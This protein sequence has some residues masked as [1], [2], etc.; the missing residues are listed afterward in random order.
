MLRE[1]FLWNQPQK[2]PDFVPIDPWNNVL[3]SDAWAAHRAGH[4]IQNKSN[5]A[6]VDLCHRQGN[7]FSSA[8]I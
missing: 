6:L 1:T 3:I 7:S 5:S 2:N 4:T 8:L